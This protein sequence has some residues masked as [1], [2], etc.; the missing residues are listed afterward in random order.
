MNTV[1]GDGPVLNAKTS[2]PNPVNKPTLLLA[3]LLLTLPLSAQERGYWRAASNTARSITGDI[4]L[5]EEKL[6]INFVGFTVSRIR[7]LQKAEIGALFDADTNAPATASLY[8]LNI[9]A[10]RKFLRKN[11]LCGAED[12]QWMVTYAAGHDLRVAFFSNPNPPLLT[13]EAIANSTDLCGT[14]SYTR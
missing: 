3:L 5:S 1:K 6:I 8:R 10:T 2:Y 9:P 4:T 13:P 11:T 7:A 14:F 12:T